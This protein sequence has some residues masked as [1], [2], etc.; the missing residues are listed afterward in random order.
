MYATL[1]GGS[2]SEGT[3]HRMAIDAQGNAYIAGFTNSSGFPTP[4]GH[5]TSYGG[6]E[7][8][9]LIKLDPRGRIAFS[10][11]IGGSGLESAFGP[12]V[13]SRGNIHTAGRS[14]SA[15]FETTPNA[16]DRTLGGDTDVFYQIYSPT[17]ALL[18]S[19]FLGGIGMD[20]CRF[21]A[22]D[23]Q[24]RPVLASETTTAAFPT[25]PDAHDRVHSG[26]HDI[27]ITRLNVS[28][29]P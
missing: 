10:T 3:E 26:R 6:D 22:L 7:D 29:H 18:Y 11:Y 5:D 24:D 1:I 4:N 8:G 25:T 23:A 19:T 27:A 17:G 13:D 28:F 12:A 21:V 2:G 16:L 15:D 14:K 9:V 20:Y